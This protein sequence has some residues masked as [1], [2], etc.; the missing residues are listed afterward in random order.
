MNP[1]VRRDVL[2]IGVLLFIIGVLWLVATGS[3]PADAHGPSLQPRVEALEAKVL[4]LQARVTALEAGPTPTPAPTPTSGWSLAFDDQFDDRTV[5]A[6]QF[7]AGGTIVRWT[8]PSG[9]L[10]TAGT[11]TADGRYI[12]F[13]TSPHSNWTDTSGHGSYAESA[14]IEIGNGKLTE[15]IYSDQ[16]GYGHTAVITPLP[17]GSS[18]RGGLTGMRVAVKARADALPGFKGVF[19]LWADIAETNDDLMQYGEI[20]GPEGPFNAVPDAFMHRTN[21]SSL[22][23]QVHFDYPS[24]IRWQDWHEYVTEWLPGESVRYLVDGVLVG[25]TTDRV[26]TT[27][28]HFNIQ[29]ETNTGSGP[30]PAPNTSGILELDYVRVWS[31]T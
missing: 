17:S 23:D 18:D 11:R 5:A 22:S 28:M 3:R 29:P 6:G 14:V 8:G 30:W 15:R 1:S 16:N 21:G 12:A 19:L 10:R 31:P 7:I 2:T 4:D 20:D 13:G 27:S 24:T 26:P 9:T 25:E